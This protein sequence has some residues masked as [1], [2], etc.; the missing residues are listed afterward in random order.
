MKIDISIEKVLIYL[1]IKL[2]GGITE[3]G[4]INSL[5]KSQKALQDLT[6]MVMKL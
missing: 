1:K 4:S 3:L 5:S 2:A 6:K